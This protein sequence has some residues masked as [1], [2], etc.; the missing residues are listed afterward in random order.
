MPSFLNIFCFYQVNTISV[1]YCAHFCM[2][3]SLGISN[4]LEEI[5]N[6]SYSI[7]FLY[8]FALISKEGFLISSCYFLE[9]CIRTDIC[10][11][12]SLPLASLLF[13]VIWKASSIKHFAFLHFFSWGW[14]WS[15]PPV[16]C[17]ELLSIVIP[18]LCL[19]DLITWIYF[20]LPLY[21]HKGLI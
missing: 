7:V 10:F 2:K 13:S 5:S 14:S 3:C 20:S 11:L 21:N 6:L 16:L 4:F 1:L 9:L 18:A 8:F 19:S 12:F 17:H 15:L